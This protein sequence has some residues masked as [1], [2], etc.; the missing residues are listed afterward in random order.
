MNLILALT[1]GARSGR[2]FQN[3]QPLVVILHEFLHRRAPVVFSHIKGSS[4]AI[5]KQY[6]S[7][8]L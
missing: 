3:R 4:P 7:V 6:L 1:G 8:T 2:R 5:Y